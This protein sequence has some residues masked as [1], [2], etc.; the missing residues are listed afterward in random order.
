MG[1]GRKKNKIGNRSKI[2]L[3]STKNGDIFFLSDVL[4]RMNGL[5]GT[6]NG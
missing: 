6:M 3:T 4:N 2:G 1:F 5:Y